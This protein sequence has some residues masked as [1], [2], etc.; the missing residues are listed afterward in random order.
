MAVER[1]STRSVSVDIRLLDSLDTPTIIGSVIVTPQPPLNFFNNVAVVLP[2]RPLSP[3]QLFTAPLYAH[4]S[5][6]VSTLSVRCACGGLSIENLEI[7]EAVSL[8]VLRPS[9]TFI[10]ICANSMVST[11]CWRF[12]NCWSVFSSRD[13]R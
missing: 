1:C 5:Y 3:A 4:A 12:S 10:S 9:T 8:P 11:I 13:S 7:N 6:P 2:S